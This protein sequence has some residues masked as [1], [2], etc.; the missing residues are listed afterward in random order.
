[1]PRCSEAMRIL[2]VSHDCSARRQRRRGS[3]HSS[4]IRSGQGGA[5][6]VEYWRCAKV[7]RGLRDSLP[8]SSSQ[9]C[10]GSGSMLDMDMFRLVD[11]AT[12]CPEASA[13]TLFQ[14]TARYDSQAPGLPNMTFSRRTCRSPFGLSLVF[15]AERRYVRQTGVTTQ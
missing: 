15:A 10:R 5:W 11:A 3:V 14:C 8:L 6:V 4:F 1:V 2:S 13:S 9:H 12:L 7:R